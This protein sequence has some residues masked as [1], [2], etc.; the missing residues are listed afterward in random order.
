MSDDLQYKPRS[1]DVT[2]G[3]QRA[4]ARAMLRAVGMGDDDFHK[5][6]IGVASSWNEVTPC[7]LHLDKL[8]DRAKEGVREA[9]GYPIEFTTIAVSDGISMGTEGMRASLIS[10]ECIADSVE[11][12]VHA[13]RFDGVVTIAGCDKSLP[14]M[15]MGAMRL[16]LPTVFCYGGTI[17]PG[18]F[19]ERDVTIQ[20][21]FEAVGA[22]A[23][24]RMSAEDLHDLEASACPGAGSCAGHY[25]ANTMATAVEALGL[26]LPGSASP[27][28]IS[29]RRADMALRSGRA[30]VEQL[31]AGIRPHDIV[32]RKSLENAV[33]VVMA[34]GGSTNAV[35]HLLAIAKEAGVKLAIDEFDKISRKTPLLAD[36]RPWGNYTAPEMHE[37]G[38]MGV[39]AKRLLD[40]GLL[41]AGELTVT[42]KTI[43]DEARAAREAPGQ[44][45]IRPLSDPLKREGGMVI[46]RGNLAPE[47]CVA[48]ISGQKR[49]FH[50]GPAR[51]FE[52]EEDSFAA[53]KAGK[54]KPNDV[55][56]IRWEGPKG[57]PGMREMLH[58]TGALQGAGLG[59]AVALMTDG[60][61]S[62]ATHGFMI[63]HIA[64]E[65]AEGGP[66]AALRNGDTIVIDIKKRKLNVEL[67]AAEIK[68]RLKSAKRPKPRYTWGVLAKYARLVSSASDGAVT[69]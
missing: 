54:I 31:R 50:R 68:K 48:K 42:G 57:G 38:G 44:K 63:G 49:D 16:D 2:E 23:A 22:H 9:G 15:V 39:V 67:S 43:G 52:R 64:P 4:P 56:V 30:V 41:N 53:V 46:L 7:N 35:L 69:G 33:T 26:S 21:V 40:A 59:D 13:E 25:T 14:G 12:V 20:D 11:L 19:R 8:A 3:P 65:A 36:M 47:G 62:G 1:R 66:I 24:G 37:A 5:P 6:L 29:E 17:M 18:R 27:P 51:V 10:R 60:R 45:V 34:T 58:V 28:A 32:T 61:F 55:I